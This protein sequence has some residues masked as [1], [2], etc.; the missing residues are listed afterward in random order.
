M[1]KPRLL[2]TAKRPPSAKALP[3]AMPRPLATSASIISLVISVLALVVSGISLW[4]T[5]TTNLPFL[6]ASIE[7]LHDGSDSAPFR[8]RV[9]LKNYGKTPAKL[10][11]PLAA[12][13]VH[14]TKEPFSP[15]FLDS[16]DQP[17]RTEVSP[18]DALVM[19]SP[20]PL[21][22]FNASTLDEIDSGKKTIWVYGKATYND[23]FYRPH[24]VR[25]C[26]KAIKMTSQQ[27]PLTFISCG[28]EYTGSN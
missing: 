2:D 7:L 16:I 4:V 26:F 9:E 8:A 19:L 1:T 20:L 3:P 14:S 13:G 24:E 12:F 21:E 17:V 23:V 22:R 18:G 25:W 15:D 5:W 6:S 11:K 10:V 28:G 27:L